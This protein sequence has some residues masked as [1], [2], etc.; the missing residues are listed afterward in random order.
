MFPKPATLLMFE[1]YL[2]LIPCGLKM[3][4][5]GQKK[6]CTKG[7]KILKAFKHVICL[8]GI[9]STLLLAKLVLIAL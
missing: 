1:F 4:V 6:D 8:L 9:E 3:F 2:P 7:K 5:G